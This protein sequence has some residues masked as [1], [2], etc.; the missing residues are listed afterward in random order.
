MVSLY[1]DRINNA[2]WTHEHAKLNVC[3]IDRLRLKK[4]PWRINLRLAMF[5]IN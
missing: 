1:I 3:A 5:L 4:S 2:A